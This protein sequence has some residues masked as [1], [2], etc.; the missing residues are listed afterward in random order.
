M[1][2]SPLKR[3]LRIISIFL[4]FTLS[5]A[6]AY[7]SHGDIACQTPRAK[8]VMKITDQKVSFLE[9]RMR[10]NEGREI[11]SINSVRTRASGQG[12]TKILNFEGKKHTIHIED[13]NNFSSVNDYIVI[14]SK[15][16]HEI[17]YPLEC[18]RV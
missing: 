11:A 2:A 18:E 16:G 4:G 12:F 3:T 6:Q 14:K 15:Q 5:M 7:A 1:T 8:K 17:T 10:M 9:E 13:E